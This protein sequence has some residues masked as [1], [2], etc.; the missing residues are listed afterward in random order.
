MAYFLSLS[1][2][3]SLMIVP[4]QFSVFMQWEKVLL[5]IV[6]VLFG[7]LL[8]HLITDFI[9][10]RWRVWQRRKQLIENTTII[11]KRL[12]NGGRGLGEGPGCGSGEESDCEETTL[13]IR[14][15][16][17]QEEHRSAIPVLLE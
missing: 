1:L 5:V 16:A 15:P 7:V 12:E 8:I 4:V 3:L 9:R 11:Y 17:T 6:A 14:D 10:G 2:S 13:L